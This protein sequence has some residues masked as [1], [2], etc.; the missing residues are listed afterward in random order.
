MTQ[1]LDFWALKESGF[2]KDRIESTDWINTHKDD[3]YWMAHQLVNALRTNEPWD[4]AWSDRFLECWKLA[5][6]IHGIEMTL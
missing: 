5:R 1:E 4:D 2:F 3:P 6:E